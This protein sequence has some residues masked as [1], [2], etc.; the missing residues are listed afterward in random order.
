LTDS[1]NIK[2]FSVKFRDA[3]YDESDYARC[4]ADHL[5]IEHHILEIEPD[6]AELV[7]TLARH[8]GDLFGDSSCIPTYT[9][10]K[11]ASEHVKVILSGDGGDELFGGYNRYRAYKY[12][13]L[14]RLI[15]GFIKN[16]FLKLGAMSGKGAKRSSFRDH[17]GRFCRTLLDKGHAYAAW[18]F[19]MSHKEKH[20]MMIPEFIHTVPDH[21]L[22]SEIYITHLMVKSRCFYFAEKAM[23][24]DIQTYLP[25]DLLQKVDIA[26]MANSLEVRSPFL[27][28]SLV[29]YTA[30]LPFPYKINHSVHKYILRQAYRHILPSKILKRG[31]MGFAVPLISYLQNE[32]YDMANDLLG[33]N[34]AFVRNVFRQDVIDSIIRDLKGTIDDPHFIFALLM[35]ELWHH[36]FIRQ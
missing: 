15:P 10:S 29:E 3:E 24:A 28:T 31:K 13:T 2:A 11:A 36:Q 4:T 18:V 32:L 23:A 30:S 26:A 25:G 35:C 1:K 20:G 16:P 33:S 27:D 17:V 14:L 8:Y 12:Q 7:Q 6:I 5:G 22:A 21:E 19:L 9:I 34:D